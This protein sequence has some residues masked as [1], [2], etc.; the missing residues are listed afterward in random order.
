MP[1]IKKNSRKIWQPERQAHEGRHNSNQKLYNSS[2]WRKTSKRKRMENPL[3]EVCK[4]IN[5]ITGSEVTDHIITI[6]EG[7]AILDDNNHMAMCHNH[8]NKKSGMEKHKPILVDFI[9]NAY[10]EKIPKNKTDIIELLT[11][12]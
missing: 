4:S 1:S 11:K 6:N 3:C 8:H 7:G 5:L 2:T 10:G 12:N 9:Y